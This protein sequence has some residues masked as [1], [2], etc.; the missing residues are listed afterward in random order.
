MDGSSAPWQIESAKSVALRECQTDKERENHAALMRL[1]PRHLAVQP[2]L[3][4]AYQDRCES[5]RLA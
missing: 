3:D 4:R 1:Q 2:K 5:I